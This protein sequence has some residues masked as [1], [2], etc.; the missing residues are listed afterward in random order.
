MAELPLPARTGVEKKKPTKIFILAGL[1]FWAAAIGLWI[2]K[3]WDKAI[4]IAHNG[5]RQVAAATVPAQL[6]S[7]FGMSTVLALF[8]ILFI[9]LYKDP[10][11]EDVRRTAWII[12]LSFTLAGFAGELLKLIFARPRPFLEYAGKIIP[13]IRPDKWS[14]PSGHATKIS[15]LV[16]PVI[17][18]LRPRPA[19]KKIL[20]IVLVLVAICV[21]Y[22]RIV[23]GVHYLS[24][25]LGGIG[26]ALLFLPLSKFL[27]DALFGKFG[28]DDR[29]SRRFAAIGACTLGLLA[30]YLIKT[31]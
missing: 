23:L 31:S 22:S 10:D 13:I 11:S 26:T 4:Q 30:I 3:D 18:F 2:Q 21:A 16:L 6:F 25:I 28:P 14:L 19:T 7:I 9:G 5:L 1:A 29:T 20:K 8:L 15:A 27:S 12:L 17:F 24:D